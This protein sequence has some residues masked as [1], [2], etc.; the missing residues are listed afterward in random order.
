MN[1]R[2]EK[3]ITS[4]EQFKM[5][6]NEFENGKLAKTIMLISKDSDYSFCFAQL[7]SCVI[8]N[9][10]LKNGEIEKSEHYYKMMANSHPDIKIFPVKDKLLVADSFEIVSES[11]IRPIFAEKKIFI[12]KNIEQSMETA[13]NKLLKT[14]EEPQN[15]VHFILTSS[16]VNLVLPTI[17][18]RCNK[19][20]LQKLKGHEILQCLDENENI[21]LVTALSEGYLGRA[22][23]LIKMANLKELFEKVLSVVTKLKTSKQLLSFSKGLLDFSSEDEFI[24][25]SFSLIF[26]DLLFLKSGGQIRFEMY[27]DEL[28]SIKDEYSIKAIT[29]IEKHIDKAVR[30]L[31]YNCN[32]TLVLENLLLNILEVKYLCR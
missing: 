5:L 15:N 9:G 1:E 19:I 8:L 27:K 4:S 24:F 3:I 18:S 28:D 30:E 22:E 11:S 10:G 12:I 2:L 23:K 26:E 17:K 29:M 32:F 7:L 13:Q 6:A 20:E 16:N 14:L 25:H 21:E 31:S